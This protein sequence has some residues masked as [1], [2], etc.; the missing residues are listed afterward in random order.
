MEFSAHAEEKE[1]LFAEGTA[2][3]VMAVDEVL[4]DNVTTADPFWLDFNG[5]TITIVYVF[6]AYKREDDKNMTVKIVC[7]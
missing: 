6:H 5:K 3:A 1:V 2:V 7:D 4:I